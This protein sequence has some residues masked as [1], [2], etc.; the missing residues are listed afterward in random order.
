MLK[1][2]TRMLLAAILAMAIAVPLESAGAQT[3]P[4]KQGK[5]TGTAPETTP[6]VSGD[7]K[8]VT[9]KK[10]AKKAMKKEAK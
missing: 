1:V 3:P 6:P 8:K 5:E 4:A 9:K 2:A 10:A 7:K